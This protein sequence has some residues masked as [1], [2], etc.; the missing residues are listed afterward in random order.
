ML[1]APDTSPRGVNIPG[2]DESWG[3]L[4]RGQAFY[5]N[6]G[7]EEP[8]AQH[9]QMYDYVDGRAASADWPGVFS[10]ARWN[11]WSLYGRSWCPHLRAEKSRPVCFGFGFSL[12]S[13]PHPSAP[14][15]KRRL[16]DT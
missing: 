7:P 6:A 1:V 3:L 13:L 9:Y 14:G 12:R 8:W 5:V 2:E 10:A 16:P 15:G 4:A 11:F